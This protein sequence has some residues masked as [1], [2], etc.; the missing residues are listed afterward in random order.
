MDGFHL[1]NDEL[2]RLGRRDRKG[3]PDTFDVDGYTTM[4]GRL[5]NQDAPTIYAP[6]FDRH[7]EEAV[8]S[9]VPVG[10]ETPLVI[11]EGNYLLLSGGGWANV[12]PALDEVWF[13]DVAEATRVSRL[14]DRQRGHG[15]SFDDAR[16]WTE[17]VD[18]PNSRYTLAGRGEADLIVMVP[19]RE[20]IR[21]ELGRDL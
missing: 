7:L 12:R 8:G 18:V 11:T 5:R 16:R 17:Q 14:V 13:L 20:A 3:A 2:I 10:R 4:L 15:I 21:G 1:G 19:A 6:R 9:S